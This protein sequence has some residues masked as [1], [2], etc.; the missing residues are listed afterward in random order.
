MPVDSLKKIG[1]AAVVGRVIFS[2]AAQKHAIKRH[3][4]EF[5]RCRPYLSLAVNYP[6]HVG[7]APHHKGIGC[8]LIYEHVAHGLIVL[9]AVH[10]EVL[11]ANGTY[12]VK[13]A[14]P[15]DR[16]TLDRRIRKGY[17]IATK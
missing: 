9:V 4:A 15:I 2:I 10:L 6:T 17:V 13:S 11:N 14:Y 7:Q 1:I 5:E 12:I 16:G 8:E 3:A